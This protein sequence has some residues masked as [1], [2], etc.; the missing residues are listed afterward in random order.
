MAPISDEIEDGLWQWVYNVAFLHVHACS[1]MYK[2]YQCI[3]IYISDMW[4]RSTP[5]ISSVIKWHERLL[6]AQKNTGTG[7]IDMA[8]QSQTRALTFTPSLM[9]W[10]WAS[11]QNLEFVKSDTCLP[12]VYSWIHLNPWYLEVSCRGGTKT[13]R[14]SYEFLSADWREGRVDEESLLTL[15]NGMWMLNCPLAKSPLAR[16]WGNVSVRLLITGC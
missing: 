7:R 16:C 11:F 12:H 4:N 5:I 6:H 8:W 13:L 9:V 15:K 1:W 2:V 14:R 3:Y 10:C